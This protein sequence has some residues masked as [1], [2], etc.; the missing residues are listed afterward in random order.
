MQKTNIAGV[1]VRDLHYDVAGRTILRGVDL[2]VGPGES[3][4]ITGPSG[5][6][7]STLLSCL[8]GLLE[9]TGGSI[10][11]DGQ[12]LTGVS[13]GQ[14]AGV[15]LRS[16]G[17]VYQFGELLPELS[18]LENVALPALMAGASAGETYTRAQ[19]LLDE[20]G[21]GHVA[22]GETGVISGG[23]RQRTAV[24]RALIGNPR[25]V[26]ADEPTGAL[27]G[28]AALAV[29]DL[30]FALPQQRSCSLVVVTHNPEIA[31]RADRVLV[32]REGRLHQDGVAGR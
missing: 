25:L 9:P 11:L 19:A 13:A 16:I 30:L 18:P 31:A 3:V 1:D 17:M 28:E 22:A 27:D 6:G 20:L 32:M 24:A 2:S 23:E 7:K 10:T 4:A 15:R 26:L 29:A 8:S 21:V 5:C 14:R 12:A